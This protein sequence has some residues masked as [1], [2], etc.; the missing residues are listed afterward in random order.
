M[1]EAIDTLRQIDAGEYRGIGSQ[2]VS[3]G[4]E[5]DLP[6]NVVRPSRDNGLGIVGKYLASTATGI[7]QE[8]SLE[9]RLLTSP[10]ENGKVVDTRT[11]AWLLAGRD[12]QR[13]GQTDAS[14]LEADQFVFTARDIISDAIKTTAEVSK[15]EILQGSKKSATNWRSLFEG[16][17]KASTFGSGFQPRIITSLGG[18]GGEAPLA[19]P[20]NI[21]PGLELSETLRDAGYDPTMTVT[22][23][24]QYG[25]ECNDLEPEQASQNWSAT[26]D[27][28]QQLLGRFYPEAEDTTAFETLWPGGLE[29]Y[30]EKL[31]E[32]ARD[33]CQ[34]NE[35]LRATAEQYGADSD[36]FVRY[37]LSHTQAFRDWQP[38]PESPF[39]IK[40]GAPSEVRF[41][42]WQEEVIEQ[43]LPLAEG[44]VPNS[45]SGDNTR[46]G[47]I[48]LYYPRVGNRPPYYPDSD[49]EPR[50]AGSY[51]TDFE[52]F[53]WSIPDGNPSLRRYDDL[54]QNLEKTRV[55]PN[56]YL[57]LF[58]EA[59]D[60]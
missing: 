43:A 46:Y 42:R 3:L 16:L 11:L 32:A 33:C 39:V 40:V 20:F 38:T 35:S 58:S 34:N 9:T 60:E 47:Q 49:G 59:Q 22:S 12:A 5:V 50:L 23:A 2:L 19:A 4:D 14:G 7:A 30:P 56:Q 27:A 15:M 25:V 51:P 26:Y 53:L 31:V 1:L 17:V 44:F 18:Y 8:V 24:A 28:Y 29:G 21:L 54:G 48:S 45:I 55:K 13:N 37:M 6:G 41:S 57:A 10:V 36:D 52:D